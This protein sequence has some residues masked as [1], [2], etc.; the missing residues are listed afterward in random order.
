MECLSFLY[1]IFCRLN[2]PFDTLEEH[3]LF[4]VAMLIGMDYVSLA[5]KYPIGN[6]GYQAPLVGTGE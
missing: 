5:L 3:A 4:L 6:L 1:R 2:G